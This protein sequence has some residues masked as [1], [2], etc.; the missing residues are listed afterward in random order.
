[1]STVYTVASSFLFLTIILDEVKSL[2]K[3]TGT[4]DSSQGLQAIDRIS[5]DPDEDGSLINMWDPTY[6][7]TD[8][9]LDN[10]EWGV[11]LITF[12]SPVNM[13]PVFRKYSTSL[14][15]LEVDLGEITKTVVDETRAENVANAASAPNVVSAASPEN[16]TGNIKPISRNQYNKNAP[17][18]TDP[19]D[20][21]SG[22][23]P[24]KQ[25]GGQWKTNFIDP[26]TGQTKRATASSALKAV[27][28]AKRAI[29]SSR[30]QRLANIK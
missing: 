14:I 28:T 20:P 29:N 16:T 2:Y 11:F 4:I 7:G 3:S 17:N 8:P 10:Y 21:Y 6:T 19:T 22:I 18:G 12:G 13:G 27:N 15:K 5:D 26:Y 24:P 30:N 9:D 1:M 25:A 23:G